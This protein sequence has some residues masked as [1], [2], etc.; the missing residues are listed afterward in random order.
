MDIT[1]LILRDRISV[2]TTRLALFCPGLFL[3]A[4]EVTQAVQYYNADE[5]LTSPADRC[6]DNAVGIVANKPDWVRA[7][8]PVF[9][10]LPASTGH[11]NCN[12]T[13]IR[14]DVINT[15]Y[16]TRYLSSRRENETTTI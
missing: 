10:G 11:W 13:R 16:I 5:H 9:S 15:A 12:R 6:A 7:Y 4:I 8:H 1:K 14:K 2:I 3:S